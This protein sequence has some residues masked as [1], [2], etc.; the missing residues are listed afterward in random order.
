MRG[1][2]K[3]STAVAVVVALSLGLSGCGNPLKKSTE[4]EVSAEGKTL[5]EAGLQYVEIVN[6]DI[7]GVA[8]DH[9]FS[10]SSDNMRTVLGSIYVTEKVLFNERQSPLFSPAELQILSNTLSTGLARAEPNEDINFVTLGVHQGTLA[11]ERQS[12]SGRVFISNGK[13]N[14]IFGLIHEE[15]SDKNKYTGQAID[16][17]VNPLLPG[18]RRVDSEPAVRVALDNGQSYYVDPETGKERTDWIVIDIPTVLAMAA[19]RDASSQDGLVSPELKEDIARNKQ[20][21]RNL[22]E[23]MANI[24]EVLFDMSEK[25]DKLQKELESLKK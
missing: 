6:R 12:D 10:I 14:I 8:N 17:R 18:T 22:R 25:M 21:T 23:D 4:V 3:Y 9:P 20:E 5:Y 19:E 13:L 24:K 1:F 15:Y 7:P 2:I 11:K 16:R